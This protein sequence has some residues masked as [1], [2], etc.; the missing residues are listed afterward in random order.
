M[1][2]RTGAQR[3]MSAMAWWLI[4]IGILTATLI[5]LF[6]SPDEADESLVVTESGTGYQRVRLPLLDETA[7]ELSSQFRPLSSQHHQKLLSRLEQFRSEYRP[8]APR[9]EVWAK[10]GLESRSKVASQLGDDL[11][12]HELGKATQELAMPAATI[13]SPL[14]LV[15][16]E[17]DKGIARQLLAALSVYLTGEVELH[18]DDTVSLSEM[19]LYLLGEPLFSTQGTAVFRPSSD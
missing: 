1:V 14:V 18:F 11:S 2:Y 17:K 19:K 5:L 9:L 3:D 12:R 13:T 6:G 8:A 16:A 7:G 10:P 4:P 15:C